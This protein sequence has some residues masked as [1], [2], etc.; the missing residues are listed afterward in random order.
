MTF[1]TSE[2]QNHGINVGGSERLASLLG[3]GLLTIYGLTRGSFGGMAMAALG[4]G[5]L[6]RGATGHC[7]TYG[8]LGLN[9][10]QGEGD[11]RNIR[12]R[13]SVTVLRPRDELFVFWRD[14][15]NLPLFMSHLESVRQMDDKRSVWTA[16]SP[17][18]LAPM[19][20]EAEIVDEAP[21]E[22]IAWRSLPG[23][24]IENEGEVRFVEA[25]DGEGT[26]VHVTIEYHPSRGITGAA[27]KWINP[28]L[29]QMVRE[30]V[31]RFKSLM[32]TGEV[33]TV[34]GQPRGH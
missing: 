4:G 18:G 2:M 17:G 23:S 28:L 19:I 5:L 25:P 12:M 13:E 7:A 32:E 24:D 30:D 33:P 15:E 8:K 11:L 1:S 22:R 31:R 6:Y 10:A 27:A 21:G 16:H 14:L 34:E 3:G 26:E 20:W 29:S 9:T